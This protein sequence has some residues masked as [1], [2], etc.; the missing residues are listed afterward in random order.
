MGLRKQPEMLA[1]RTTVTS[2]QDFSLP[3]MVTGIHS[4]EKT[5][6]KNS[7]TSSVAT[8]ALQ[9]NMGSRSPQDQP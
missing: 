8:P 3:L 2:V 1:G 4:G 5:K 6:T 7:E 9:L